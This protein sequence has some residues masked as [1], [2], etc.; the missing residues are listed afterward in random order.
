MKILIVKKS[1]L[2]VF[3][4][5]TVLFV[6]GCQGP[7]I[8][9]Q[10]KT[11]K[12]EPETKPPVKPP[13]AL[14]KTG[15]LSAEEIFLPHHKRDHV[16]KE[17]GTRTKW[18]RLE[19]HEPCTLAISLD[20]LTTT[21][22]LELQLLNKRGKLLATGIGIG[23]IEKISM[24]VESGIY[25]IQ[26]YVPVHRDDGGSYIL[27]V[28]SVT[29][30]GSSMENPRLLSPGKTVTDSVGTKTGTMSRWFKFEIKTPANINVQLSAGG[31]YKD[32][33]MKL[34]DN[35]GKLLI[36]AT[37]TGTAEKISKKVLEGEYYI[38]VKNVKD[39]TGCDYSLKLKT[40]LLG[41]NA[42]GASMEKAIA[43]TPGKEPI[44]GSLGDIYGLK[45]R[46][47]KIIANYNVCIEIQ[48]FVVNPKSALQLELID[49]K[50][51]PLDLEPYKP[52]KNTFIKHV[53]T[54]IYYLKVLTRKKIGDSKYKL[55]VRLN[56]DLGQ[57]FIKIKNSQ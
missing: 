6:I 13:T 10:D 44:T 1:C 8:Y 56:T 27:T 31:S 43:I 40:Y 36:S 20:T 23:S 54:G 45:S 9:Q 26:V 33:D 35:T 7:S 12:I 51:D 3:A 41:L 38:Q 18:Y 4:I 11:P 42:M 16:G 32:L 50:K 57:E 39:V 34:L 30:I 52:K 2:W 14:D 5:I 25:H 55:Y 22:S 47:Y 28:E 29:G 49:D 19:I 17:T 53:G 21:R 46:W 37:G 15:R 48:F 24:N